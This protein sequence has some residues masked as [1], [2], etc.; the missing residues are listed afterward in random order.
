MEKQIKILQ[1]INTL[2]VGGAEKL[3]LDTI[4]KYNIKGLPVDVLVFKSDSDIFLNQLKVMGCCRVI[5]LKQK[6]VYNPINILKLIKYLKQYDIAHVHLFP[7]QYF[8]PLAKLLS[9]SKIKLILTEHS[10]NNKRRSNLLFRI[11]DKQI[12]KFYY[13]MICITPKIL[14]ITKKHTSLKLSKFILIENGVDLYKIKIATPIKITDLIETSHKLDINII[15]VSSFHEPKDQP[16]LIK[17]ITYLP[18]NYKLFFAGG[19][20]D[21]IKSK[22][23][24]EKL[25]L[26]SRVCFLGKRIDIPSIIKAMDVIV[27]SS[28][29]EGL[30]LSSIEAM[31][32]GRPFVASDVP[33]LR[34]IVKGAGILFKQGDSKALASSIQKLL[35]NKLHYDTT[36]KS[37]QEKAEQYDISFMVDKHIKLYQETSML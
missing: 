4:P 25:N 27:L 21:L 32:S 17:A 8:V 26:E 2:G 20:V 19:G 13:K 31:A 7:A 10:T 3:L 24:V 16:T 29:F 30:S 6:S 33:G 15:Q 28:K 36:V 34:D 22:K 9:F 37:C 12:Y 14:E 5:E 18:K 23:L 1:I 11:L 35:D